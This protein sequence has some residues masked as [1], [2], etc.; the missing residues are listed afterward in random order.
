M[1][2]Y[3][4]YTSIYI[5]LSIYKRVQIMK[6]GRVKAVAHTHKAH[7]LSGTMKLLTSC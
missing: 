6:M 4:I 2:I 5:R 7:R 3:L 1:I